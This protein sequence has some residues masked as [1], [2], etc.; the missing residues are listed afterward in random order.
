MSALRCKIL[1][2]AIQTIEQR[3]RPSGSPNAKKHLG[4][5]VK[6]LPN[7]R[8]GNLPYCSTSYSKS[9]VMICVLVFQLPKCL[10]IHDQW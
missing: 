1:A 8:S 2:E 5:G 4:E 6:G 9:P 3:D 10:C 7:S